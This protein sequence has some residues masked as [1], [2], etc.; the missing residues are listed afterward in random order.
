M[1]FELST[2]GSFYDPGSVKD[3]EKLGFTFEVL[4]DPMFSDLKG[5]LHKTN[6]EPV[7]I[8]IDTLEELVAFAKEWGELVVDSESI[9]IYDDY[10]E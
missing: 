4:K 3:L 7:T 1:R 9:E 6:T 8:E 10:R 5:K 2:S